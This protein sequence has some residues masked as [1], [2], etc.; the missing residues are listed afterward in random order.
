M[1]DKVVIVGTG[2]LGGS[3]AYELRDRRLAQNV[4]GVCRSEKTAEFA[5]QNGVVDRCEPLEE[6]V[7]DA[8]LVILA[9]PMQAMRPIYQQ[10]SKCIGAQTLISDVGSVK[11]S[12]YLEVAEHTPQLLEQS[13]FAHPIAGGENSGVEA[14][15][16]SL[17]K[18]KHLIITNTP[19]SSAA[20]TQRVAAMWRAVGARVLEL[21]LDEHDAI[22]AKTSHLPHVIAFTLVNYLSQQQ[23]RQQLFD[24]AAAGFYDFTRIA[25]SDA[26]MWRDICVTNQA[27]VLDA[28]RGFK[29]QI[30]EIES[31]VK[32]ADQ[33]GILE[34][35]E[36]AKQARD[37][38]LLNKAKSVLDDT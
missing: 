27:H 29:K 34:Y 28:L 35:F 23:E 4:V 3:L 21:S 11:K 33:T 17:F 32:N 38:G 20:A 15:K 8:D 7:I 19:E 22:F 14:A 16:K 6:A 9:V 12:L 13:V 5:V 25:S 31:H 26:Q 30:E 18:N 37:S 10:L 2:L 24:L 1:F 36:M